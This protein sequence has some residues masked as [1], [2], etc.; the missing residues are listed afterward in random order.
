[1]NNYFK[2]YLLIQSI[3]MLS[4]IA[5]DANE[6]KVPMSIYINIKKDLLIIESNSKEKINKFIIKVCEID[7]VE[8][9]DLMRIVVNSNSRWRQNIDYPPPSLELDKINS[10]LT[11]AREYVKNEKETLDKLESIIKLYNL[12]EIHKSENSYYSE[13]RFDDENHFYIYLFY[14]KK[15]IIVSLYSNIILNLK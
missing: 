5:A 15:N 8:K 3:A 2:I 10:V 1:M 7:D 9:K 14:P 12:S 6:V 11:L 4:L 13:I